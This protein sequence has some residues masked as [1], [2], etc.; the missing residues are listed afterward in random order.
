MSARQPAVRPLWM[1]KPSGFVQTL[2]VLV[3]A[4]IVLVML[5]PVIAV[6]LQSFASADAAL[7]GDLIP[8]SFST[9]AYRIILS[10]GVVT[11]S[12][13]ITAGLTIVGTFLSMLFTTTMAYGLCRVRDVPFAKAALM[14]VIGTMFFGAGIIPMYLMVQWLGLLNTYW[15]LILPGLIGAFNLIVVRNFFMN[16]PQDVFEAAR[17]DG[18]GEIRIFFSLVLPLSKA[19]LAVIALFYAVGY[20]NTFFSGMLYL[21]DSAMWPIQVVLNQ[22]VVQGAPLGTLQN[23]NMPPAPSEAVRAAVVVLA[24]LP[25]LIVYPFLQ[26][27]F[28][29]GVLTGAI[30]G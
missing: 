8:K 23:P 27:F 29:K 15:A 10:G 14:L 26:R 13:L 3:I 16:L 22:Y 18:A 25:I 19:V 20:W 21:D 7:S 9:S 4:M 6:V 11:R 12:L 2:K 28:T 30:K 1:E 5:Y 24:T 17:I